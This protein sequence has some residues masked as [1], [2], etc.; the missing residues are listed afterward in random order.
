M[1]NATLGKILRSFHYRKSTYLVPLFKTFV[2]P[3]LEYSA[4]AW[5]PWLQKDCDAIEKV[6]RRLIRSLSDKRGNDYEERLKNAGLTTL[7]SRRQRGDMIQVF[8]AVKGI[9]RVNVDV[10]FDLKDPDN[11]RPTRAN[12]MITESGETK[13]SYVMNQSTCRLDLR[14]NFFSQRVVND[15]NALPEDAK[16]A[17]TTNEFKNIY[18]RYQS[19][20]YPN[21]DQV[22]A[23]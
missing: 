9:S 6:Q 14:K 2:R 21:S 23:A 7:Q 22:D 5:S 8:K 4:A 20:K 17:R 11:M 1:A 3:Q 10:W 16:Q 12:T 19:R 18:D 13:K 15:W